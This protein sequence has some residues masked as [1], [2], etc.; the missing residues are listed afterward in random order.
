MTRERTI[1][2]RAF[3][4]DLAT[5]ALIS[6]AICA[7]AHDL[8][9]M[10]ALVPVVLAVR[11]ALFLA[12]PDDERDTSRRGELG[13]LLVATVLGAFNDWSSVVRH[14]IYDYTVPTD[15]GRLSS[16]PLWMLLYW[17]MILRFVLT[18]CHYR[19]LALPAS[20]TG[21]ASLRVGRTARLALLLGI[22]VVTRQCIYRLYD[23]PILSFVPFVAALVVFLAV[24]RPDARRRK[25]LFGVLVLGPAVEVLYIQ[26][27][28]LHAYRLGV[29]F[30]VP[31]WIALWWGLAV[32]VWEELGTRLQRGLDGVLA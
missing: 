32:L 1:G 19:R 31:V 22:V 4:V 9:R 30:G 29:L 7:W 17:G 10:S 27:G 23:R 5:I 26:V 14:R 20:P 21:L 6:V 25:L 11:T 28:H 15:L 13:L 8:P 24:V 2:D 3:G 12:L 18:L 16:I